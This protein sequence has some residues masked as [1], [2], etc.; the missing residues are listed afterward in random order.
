MP[1]PA[2][3]RVL[4]PAI[5]PKR[6]WLPDDMPWGGI[7]IFTGICVVVVALAIGGW[8]ASTAIGDAIAS[9][10]PAVGKGA[11]TTNSTPTASAAAG[12]SSP[13]G[14]ATPAAAVAA[15]L[16]A[17]K[18]A[19]DSAANA[20]KS[21]AQL[22]ASVLPDSHASCMAQ[23]DKLA[24]ELRQ[25]A[26]GLQDA[27]RQKQATQE[28]GEIIVKLQDL[29]IR[30]HLLPPMTDGER[31]EF[32]QRALADFERIR[33]GER[34]EPFKID[35]QNDAALAVVFELQPVQVALG[36]ILTFAHKPP[37]PPANAAE[38]SY[39]QVS[40]ACRQMCRELYSVDTPPDCERKSLQHSSLNR[41]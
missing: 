8:Y 19:A 41:P 38:E 5:A 6:K 34:P 7:A 12:A 21:V 27:A 11:T 28:C 13:A 16:Q 33:R 37:A 31:N 22:P 15:P 14:S 30:W 3:T 20:A 18:S 9:A 29:A 26:T 35:V 2:T 1:M 25:A 40:D 32:N 4:G 36:D 39:V 23:R 17:L 10:R 24:A